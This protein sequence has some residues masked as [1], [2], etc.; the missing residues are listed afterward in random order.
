M[1]NFICKQTLRSNFFFKYE[2]DQIRK[3]VFGTSAGLSGNMKDSRKYKIQ[4]SVVIQRHFF[5]S[6]LQLNVEK[7]IDSS[8]IS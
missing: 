6:F 8:I 1:R 2:N 4:T 3:Q 7:K 5:F